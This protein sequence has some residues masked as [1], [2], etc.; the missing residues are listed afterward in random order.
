MLDIISEDTVKSHNYQVLARKY[1]PTN[2]TE[3]VGQDVIVRLISNAIKMNR[4]PHAFLL[5]GIRGVG[6]TTT[7]RILAKAFNCSGHGEA[8]TSEPCGNCAHCTAISSGTHQDVMEMDAA[9]H[10]SVNDIRDVIES[11]KYRPLSGRYKIYIIDEI[12]MLSL[13]AF[14]ALLK[15]LEEP[16][17]H[18]KFIFATTELQKIPVTILS[19]CQRFDLKRVNIETLYQHFQTICTAENVTIDNE[20]LT[21]IAHAADGSVRDGLSL[22]DRMIAMCGGEIRADALRKSLGLAA[23]GKIEQLFCAALQGEAKS[24]LSCLAQL[25]EDGADCIEITKSML[26]LTHLMSKQVAMGKL[27]QHTHYSIDDGFAKELGMAK[28]GMAWQI[29]QKGYQEIKS[30]VNAVHSLEMLIIRIAYSML[31]PGLKELFDEPAPANSGGS[32]VVA[33]SSPPRENAP[34]ADAL[35]LETLHIAAPIESF[36]DVLN[37]A[38]N[39]DEIALYHHLFH[40]IKIVSFEQGNIKICPIN[41]APKDIHLQLKRFLD[42]ITGANWTISV[43]FATAT[44]ISESQRVAQHTQQLKDNALQSE[45]V[46]DVLETFG[47]LEVHDVK[48]QPKPGGYNLME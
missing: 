16:P 45:I 36:Q 9:S 30:S 5:T 8:M 3:V 21:L 32:T 43:A 48:I 19:R 31:L 34:P 13:S 15:T 17:E 46:K 33:P 42:N 38:H 1:R 2:F 41:A 6:K 10:T 28:L 7:A 22:L 44:S 39:A 12:H 35:P 14:N 29:L 4:V 25:Y 40:N 37:I 18:V 24:A 20:A 26:E 23:H 27:D 47:E 11:V